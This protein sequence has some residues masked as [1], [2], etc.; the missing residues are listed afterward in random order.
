MPPAVVAVLAMAAT[1]AVQVFVESAILA[2]ILTIAITVASTMLMRRTG[3]RTNQGQEIRLKLDPA[4]PR[5][6]PLGRT[7]TG[8][9]LVHSFSYGS[10]SNVPNNAFLVRVIALSDLP[11]E[12]VVK[13]MEG[14]TQLTF[15]GDF[16]NSFVMCNQ[17][18]TESN[19]PCMGVRIYRGSDSP[20]ADA[21]LMS[22]SG[23]Q[24]TSSHKG[25]NMAYAVVR[26]QFDED[27]NAFPNGEPALTFVVDGVKC[28]DDRLDGSKP[29]RTGTHRLDTPSTWE[30]TRNA[31][32][33][34]A[35]TLRGFYS[36]NVL[37]LGA[38]AEERDL[39]DAMLISAYNTCDEDVTFS[40]GTQNRYDAGMMASS[41]NPVANILQD[42]QS[43]MDGKII[44][45][46]GSITILPGATRTPV[47]NLTD[48]DIQWS[49]EKSW[50]PKATLSELYNHITG[51]YVDEDL[52]YQERAFPPLRNT[53]WETDDGGERF[54]LQLAY[55]AITNWAR[56]QR[57][58]K[59]IHQQSRYQGTVAFILPLWAIEMEQG[60]WF[61]LTSSRWGFTTK[62]FEAATVD[63]LPSLQ[64]A[65]VGRET[66]A[67][68]DGWN[69]VVDEWAR[70]DT[71]G[72]PSVPTEL[73]IPTVVGTPIKKLDTTEGTELFGVDVTLTGLGVAGGTATSVQLEIALTSNLAGSTVL[74]TLNAQ[75]QTASFF[76][77]MPGESYSIRARSSNGYQYSDWS[78][79]DDFTTL[80]SSLGFSIITAT[81][82]TITANPG[83]A[84]PSGTFPRNHAVDVKKGATS[85]R[86]N[87]DTEY[88]IS[89]TNVTATVDN[90]DG[91]PSKGNIAITAMAAAVGYIDLTVTVEGYT[92][93]PVRITVNKYTPPVIGGG[94][95]F[96]DNSLV[97]PVNDT[98][99]IAITDIGTLTLGS[100]ETFQGSGTIEYWMGSYV[101]LSRTLSTKWQYSPAGAG[102]WTDFPSSPVVGSAAYS[103]DIETG[104]P[105]YPGSID[106]TQTQPGLAA[107]SYDL[108]LMAA[109]NTSSAD[110]FPSG[111]V[112]M[113][114]G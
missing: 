88:S 53:S 83:G 56:V 60:D 102:T 112:T 15:T 38:Q 101:G 94:N 105:A 44:D 86:L 31:A 80:G 82:L 91:S 26:Y 97:N 22:W 72:T 74:G 51:V 69:H 30:F 110:V 79:W 58:T 17:H 16:H 76:G 104:D 100:G 71:E 47:F 41:G 65:V 96:S 89:T 35:Q 28:Y 113:T 20:T 50:Q 114:A 63:L 111:T 73:P 103:G 62:Y 108:R 84:F 98:T 52:I 68:I 27:G 11:I 45:R 61:T 21:N 1:V 46:G 13:I 34:T 78:A 14:A 95:S 36:N 93:A 87:N 49:E 75:D 92:L 29:G 55:N 37:I 18:K 64:V 24:W 59:R 109:L 25:R 107:G 90:V 42:L 12:G 4:L 81:S 23:G 57:V 2:A 32:I 54:S 43:A 77:L 39:L 10:T 6:I 7:A 19:N 106:V 8:G 48:A 99:Y 5:E 85:V 9:S 3:G 66:A 40:G 67:A 70:T 33:L